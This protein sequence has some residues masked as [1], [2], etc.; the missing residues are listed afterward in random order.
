MKTP[1]PMVFGDEKALLVQLR[2]F[3]D[4]LILSAGRHQA[5]FLPQTWQQLSEPRPFLEHLKKKACV[6]ADYWTAA[7]HGWRFIWRSASACRVR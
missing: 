6:P 5:L 2:P 4:G 3:E 1:A 7:V